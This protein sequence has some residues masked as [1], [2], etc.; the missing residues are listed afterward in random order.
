MKPTAELIAG[1]KNGIAL[2][3]A[4]IMIIGLIFIVA[5]YKITPSSLE[6]MQKEIVVRKAESPNF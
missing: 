4:V 1:I 5:L 2:I 6:K 3:P